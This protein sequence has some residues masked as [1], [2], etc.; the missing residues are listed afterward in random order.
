M[1][2]VVTTREC[3]VALTGESPNQRGTR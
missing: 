3:N 1:Y 2:E